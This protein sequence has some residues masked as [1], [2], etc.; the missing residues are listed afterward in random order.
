M[1]ELWI[2]MI[3]GDDE[4]CDLVGR[5]PRVTHSY[6]AYC[7]GRLFGGSDSSRGA[8]SRPRIRRCSPR[9]LIS[10]P[11]PSAAFWPTCS[12]SERATQMS[13][14]DFQREVL[15]AR[16]AY[17][18][19]AETTTRLGAAVERLEHLNGSV[20]RHEQSI[21]ELKLDQARTA[22]AREVSHKLVSA[23]KPAVWAILG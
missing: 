8:G 20:A 10:P 18:S 14:R 17:I 15:E 3:T 21:S 23:V 2:L 1:D 16:R 4:V 12:N 19:Q 11:R 6:P 9:S 13:E 7:S 22:G 5:A